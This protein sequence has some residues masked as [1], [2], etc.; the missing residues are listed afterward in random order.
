MSTRKSTAGRQ[1]RW[2]CARMRALE[3]IE[4]VLESSNWADVVGGGLTMVVLAA[5]GEVLIPRLERIALRRGPVLGAHEY[6]T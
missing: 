5:I 6:C 4:W 1:L 2:L 3:A